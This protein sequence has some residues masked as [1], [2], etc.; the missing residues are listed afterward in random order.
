VYVAAGWDAEDQFSTEYKTCLRR[1]NI[2]S[3]LFTHIGADVITTWIAGA[4]EMMI[5]TSLVDHLAP[6]NL[7]SMDGVLAYCGKQRLPTKTV[8]NAEPLP[9]A[10]EAIHQGAEMER[11]GTT[12]D[13][14]EQPISVVETEFPM[15]DHEAM[16]YEEWLAKRGPTPAHNQWEIA[17]G[18][19]Q[20]KT[21]HLIVSIPPETPKDEIIRAAMAM[22]AYASEMD[23]AIETVDEPLETPLKAALQEAIDK[24]SK[25]EQDESDE[26]EAAIIEHQRIEQ[27][28]MEAE[29]KEAK[30]VTRRVT[31]R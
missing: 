27:E 8:A 19:H 6:Y 28:R 10:P 29:R 25:Q 16:R 13:E 23:G 18:Y 7:R 12:E 24:Q 4:V 26:D 31:R 1:I 3:I 11:R 20:V 22:L 2:A 5:I 14:P 17:H 21:E 30:K 9:P 15:D